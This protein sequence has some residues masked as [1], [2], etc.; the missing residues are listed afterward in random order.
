MWRGFAEWCKEQEKDV[1][2]AELDTVLDRF[3][4]AFEL[5]P[6][7]DQANDMNTILQTTNLTVI[8]SHFN[9]YRSSLPPTMAYWSNYF[10]MISTAL[11]MIRADR[12]ADWAL[13]LRAM[14]EMLQDFA[15]LIDN[16]TSNAGSY[17]LPTCMHWRLTTQMFLSLI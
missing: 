6:N 15:A 5:H 8:M 3:N 2:I 17:T 7:A 10:R 12:E 13:H 14:T 11:D 16:S 4:A 1:N 9:E